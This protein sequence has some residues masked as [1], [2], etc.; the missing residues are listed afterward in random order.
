MGEIR[1]PVPKTQREISISQQTPL[2]NNPNS[3]VLPLPVFQN[4]QDTATAKNFRAK[5][6]SVKGDT[7][8]PYT[9]GIGD[10]DETI[11]YYFNN[12]IKPQVYQNGTSIPVPIIYGNPERW[13]AVQKDGYYRDKNDKIM[14]PIIMFKR[15]S[16]DKTYTIG[17]KLDANNPLNY[18]IVNK[19]YQK[20]NAY[21]NFDILN[22]REPVNTYQAIVI[23]DYVTVNYEC[24]V[25]TYYIEQMNKIVEG[26]N[27]SSDS[28]WG[29]PQRFKFRARID[30][31][32]NNETLNQGEERLIKTNFNIK[33]YGYIIPNAINKNLV[34]SKKVFTSGK[35]SFDIEVVSNI[36][37]I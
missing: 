32:T 19:G 12:V 10:I 25:W 31:F 35:V 4:P 29:D 8:K 37:D 1:K 2:E 27:Y 33:M 3:A 20:G 6:V 23:P 7:D 24:I 9:V 36:D 15:T 34:A 18:A 28:Y 11:T 14:C 30:S 21:S 17:N 26:I 22:D 13:K 5:Q 16:M